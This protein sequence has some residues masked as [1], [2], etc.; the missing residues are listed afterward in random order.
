[1]KMLKNIN[2]SSVIIIVYSIILSLF[3]SM[4]ISF[5]NIDI[6][7]ILN[8]NFSLT[9]IIMFILLLISSFFIYDTKK[10][11]SFIYKYRYLLAS[12]IFI[13]LVLGKFH[14]TSIG[15]WNDYIQP[16]YNYSDKVIISNPKN[17]RS[18]EWL[19]NS[20]LMFSQKYV[21]YNINNNLVRADKTNIYLLSTAPVSDLLEIARPLSLG[22]MIFGNDYGI[23]IWWFGRVFALFFTTFELLMIFTKKNKK[24]SLF[25]SILVLGSSVIQWFFASYITEI[26]IGGQLALISFYYLIKS[27]SKLKKIL[28]SFVFII[29]MLDYCLILYPAHQIPFGYIFVIIALWM[30]FEN[31]ENNVIKKNI[32]YMIFPILI[33]LI[34]LIR[35][36]LLSNEGISAISNS[37]Y[38]GHRFTNGGNWYEW[39]RLFQYPYTLLLPFKSSGD[40]CT[41]SSFLSLFPL[42]LIIAIYYLI[43]NKKKIKQEGIFS[44]NFL[45]IGLVFLA[46]LYLAFCIFKLP[47]F[48]VKITL[49]SKTTVNA[50]CAPIGFICILLMCILMNN[51]KFCEKKEKI[52]CLFISLLLS[53]FCVYIS[54]SFMSDYANKYI[55]IVLFLIFSILDYLYLTNDKKIKQNILIACMSGICFINIIYVN[56]FTIGTDMIYKKPL[57][58]EINKIV[59][60]DKNSRWIA[61]DSFITPNYLMMNG[62]KTI[63]STNLYPNLKLWSKIDKKGKY[64][65]IYNRY[66]HII[67][68]LTNEETS[69]ELIQPDLI[70]INL[71][72]ADINILDINYIYSN[73]VI[74]VDKK[75]GINFIKIYEEDNSY[76]YKVGKS[77]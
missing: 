44:K 22:I 4:E 18:D 48:I 47:N 37:V 31:K 24:I 8:I 2:K 42:P 33:I 56:P 55:C 16:N 3:L 68:E 59:N 60:K 65:N 7:N 30:I 12:I 58:N 62:A 63:N 64:E 28:W 26:L 15:I 19:V 39:Q 34:V 1:M 13:L 54:Y 45:I 75:Y 49:L 23:S 10:V 11:T 69:F 20:P 27:K 32:K 25:G 74:D 51:I 70:K 53:L 46:V 71:N 14:C 61:L 72:Y 76:I 29:G 17:I 40:A 6:H 66:A 9:L 52:I 73:K 67:I 35:F 50:I 43:K 21:G 77:R 5:G 36:L 41:I 38:P 57:V